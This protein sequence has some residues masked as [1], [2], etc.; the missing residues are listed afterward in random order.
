MKRNVFFMLLVGICLFSCGCFRIHT[1]TEIHADGSVDTAFNMV[2]IELLDKVIEDSKNDMIKENPDVVVQKVTDGNMRGYKMSA[3]YPNMKAFASMAGEWFSTRPGVCKGIQEHKGWFF[4][5]Y[6]FDLVFMNEQKNN[7]LPQKSDF[8]TQMEQAF[9]SQVQMDFK[10]SIPYEADSNNADS[11]SGNGKVLQWN[12]KSAIMEGQRKN[13]QVTFKIWNKNHIIATI[14]VILVIFVIAVVKTW[15]LL[16][17]EK[18][19]ENSSSSLLV[20]WGSV[21]LS[22]GISA[23]LYYAPVE[24]TDKDII[25]KE[26]IVGDNLT[27]QD[28]FHEPVAKDIPKDDSIVKKAMNANGINGKIEATSEGNNPDGSLSIISNSKGRKFMIVDKINNQMAL[29]DFSK[30]IYN[31]V[32]SRGERNRRSII[33]NMLILNDVI[34]PDKDLGEWRDQ[35]HLLPVYAVYKFGAK[36]QIEPGML[37]SGK[38]IRPSH[39]HETLKE[40]KNVDLAN[41]LLTEMLALH[42]DVEKKSLEIY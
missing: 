19:E 18:S 1:D 40:Q 26:S 17:M 29:V 38:G 6:S 24:F 35:D 11:V 37:T 14:I 12:V 27:I 2:G 7:A 3:H 28:S 16:K 34:G 30:E 21:A 22:I 41:L 5:S 33:F 36:G 13:V 4:N 25:S 32:D 31:F 15:L 42:R 23:Y 10:M 8:D 39:Y 9:L 20:L